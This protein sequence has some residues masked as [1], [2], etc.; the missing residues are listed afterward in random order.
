M[1]LM[2]Q[3]EELWDLYKE[4]KFQVITKEFQNRNINE[5]ADNL[6]ELYFLSILELDPSVKILPTN[7]IFKD[8]LSAMHDYKNKNYLYAANKL[9]KWLLNKGFYSEMIIERFFSSAKES[10]QYNLIVKVCELFLSKKNFNSFY[11]KEMFYAH[12]NLKQYE[13]AIKV[14]EFYREMFDE[15]DLQVVGIIL[16]KLRKFKEAERILL[17]VYK[18]ITGKD[19]QNNYEKYEEYY[20]GKYKEL[21]EKYINNKIHDDKELTEYAMSCLFHGD[22]RTALQL[23]IDLKNKLEKVA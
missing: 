6:K 9:A 19:Y 17:G 22:Y 18:K 20:K 4:K 1:Q 12:F 2:N 23:F 10:Q 21:K 8:L 15:N 16:M 7:G 11:I 14:F 5:M 13:E 3:V